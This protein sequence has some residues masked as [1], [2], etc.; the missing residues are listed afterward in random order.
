MIIKKI[1]YYRRILVIL[2]LVL[3]ELNLSGQFPSRIKSPVVNPDLSVAFSIKA[4]NAKEVSLNFG[5]EMK[6]YPMLKNDQGVWNVTI[7]PLIPEYYTYS[8][9]V[10][11]LKI[12]DPSNPEMQV[13]QAPDFSLVNIPGT[14]PRFD[15]LQDVPHG[16][17]CILRY[18]STIQELNRKLYVYTPPGYNPSSVQ[19]YPVFYLRHGGG[20]NETSWYVEGC[21]AKILDNLLAQGKITPMI[22]VMTNGNLEK[23]VEGGAYSKEGVTI[24]TDELFTDVVPMIEKQYNVYTDK[25][26][27]AIA[28]LSM[29]GGQSFYMGLRNVDKFS[30]IGSFSSGI[31]GGIPGSSFDAEKEVPGILTNTRYFNKELKLLYISVGEQD[32]RMEFTGKVV[33]QFRKNNL[34]LKY[35]TFEGVHE[36]KVW[37]HSLENFL[38]LLFR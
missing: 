13:G 28:G 16:T 32:P 24:M 30:W 17:I 21:A 37:K 5:A 15:E 29:G 26:H 33:D 34:H 12:L 22:V 7:G 6:S 31:F 23:Q 38:Q 10:D 36:W 9:L 11:G 4:P 18:Y 20:G 8:F 27:R 25:D 3:I 1:K 2:V 35:E 14:P 19:Q